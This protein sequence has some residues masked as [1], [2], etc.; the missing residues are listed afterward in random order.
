[1][2]MHIQGDQLGHIP[3]IAFRHHHHHHHYY[4]HHHHHHH[5]YFYYYYFYNNYYYYYCHLPL[6]LERC[7]AATVVPDRRLT[8]SDLARD[9]GG[10]LEGSSTV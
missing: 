1:M 7:P 6:D 2:Q 5:H 4:H 3:S 10:M 9:L 8:Y